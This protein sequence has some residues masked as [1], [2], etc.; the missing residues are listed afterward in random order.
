MGKPINVERTNG[1]RH[2]TLHEKGQ[3][4][5]YNRRAQKP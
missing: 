3:K 1:A 5:G 4:R 2:K